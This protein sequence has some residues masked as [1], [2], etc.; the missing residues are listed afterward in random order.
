MLRVVVEPWELLAY[1]EK[2][3]FLRISIE[4]TLSG[5]NA[6]RILVSGRIVSDQSVIEED[7]I[8]TVWMG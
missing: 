2:V 7:E 3:D 4:L 5:E 6:I 8:Q 1:L